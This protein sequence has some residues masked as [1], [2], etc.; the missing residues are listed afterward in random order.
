MI[1][2]DI[3]SPAYRTKEG[4]KEETGKPWKM[5]FQQIVIHGHYVDGFPARHPRESTIQ[6]D[7]KNP[8][9]YPVGRYALSS[10]A[11]YFGDF[12]RF[13]LGRLQLQPLDKF[14]LELEKQLGCKISALKAAA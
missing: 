7:E 10:E 2:I 9:P 14:L 12:G 13:T 3:E 4:T 8:V 6:L 11:F 5:H 1:I